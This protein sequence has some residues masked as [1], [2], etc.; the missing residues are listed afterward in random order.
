MISGESIPKGSA[1]GRSASGLPLIVV[2][3]TTASG[4]SQIAVRLA[5]RFG[6]EV[7]GCDSMQVYRGFDAGTGKP[8]AE[9]CVR[10][11]HHLV[12]FADPSTDFNLGDY[13]RAGREAISGILSS[14]HRPVIAGGTG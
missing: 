12:D 4:K 6:G 3:G 2:L 5:E 9:M 13:V 8:S 10:V 11:P 14:G 7:V 1:S